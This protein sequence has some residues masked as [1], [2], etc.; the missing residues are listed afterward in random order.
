MIAAEYEYQMAITSDN[1]DRW[2]PGAWR[3]ECESHD[4]RVVWE[5]AQSIATKES[6]NITRIVDH[7]GRL[8][9]WK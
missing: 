1:P 8:V 9:V 4:P 5:K 6:V 2:L 7:R 3:F